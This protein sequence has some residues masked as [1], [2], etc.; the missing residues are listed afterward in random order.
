MINET[1]KRTARYSE[2]ENRRNREMLDLFKDAPI[3]EDEFLAN[4][5]LFINRQNL[6]RLIWMNELYK[7]IISVPGVTME[8]G[9][10]WGANLALWQSFRSMYEPYNY[11]RKIIGF[12]TFSGFGPLHE[13]DASPAGMKTGDY[14]VT[15]EYDKYLE[16]VL[17]CHEQDGP[18]AHIKKYKIAKGDAPQRLA[19]YLKECPETIIALAYFD[20]DMYESTKKC[21]ELI[22]DRVTK[23]S[24]IGFDELVSADFP[25]ET[26]AL[27]EVFGLDKYRIIRGQHNSLPAYVVIE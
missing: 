11:S 14:A 10:R 25:G 6:T 13:K 26:V 27:R 20:M 3:P 21:L 2:E 7:K 16:K 12:D 4:L 5:G 22:K 17:A 24:V 15:D 18:I 9:C 23:G 19:E 8:F 1:I